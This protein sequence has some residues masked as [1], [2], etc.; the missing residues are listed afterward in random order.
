MTKTPTDIQVE[1]HFDFG[2]P[3]AYLAHRVVP[4]IERR[5]GV[6]FSY[7][8][9]LIGGVFKATNN[10][11]PMVALDGIKNKAE[12]QQLETERFLRRHNINDY[13]RNP[14]FPINTLQLMR[15]AIAAEKTGNAKDYIDAVFQ[16][17]WVQGLDMGQTE[18]VAEALKD[19]PFSIQ[20]IIEKSSDPAIKQKLI[21]NTEN[22]VMRGNFGSPTFFV[23]DEMFFGKDKLVDVEEE[24]NRQLEV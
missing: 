12:Y 24:I 13:R 4:E 10:V 20:N 3:N 8:P 21:S 9:V 1:F 15:G 17:M 14:F 7:L 16:A 2:S 5:T 19:S 6:A 22:S 18:V 11:S 23:G